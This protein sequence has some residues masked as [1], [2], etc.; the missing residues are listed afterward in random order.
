M[1]LLDSHVLG[2]K[3]SRERATQKGGQG[4]RLL[5][6]AWP[7]AHKGSCLMKVSNQASTILE[8]MGRK[9]A[10]DKEPGVSLLLL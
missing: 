7:S 8:E 9:S 1:G 2:A 5:T 6:R 4:S 10:W 3:V